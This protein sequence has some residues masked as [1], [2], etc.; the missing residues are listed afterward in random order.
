LLLVRTPLL[1]VLAA[2]HQQRQTQVQATTVLIPL[3]E[4]LLL[5]VV[6]REMVLIRLV[7]TVVRV[8]VV[9]GLQQQTRLEELEYLVRD[10]LVVQENPTRVEAVLIGLL[11]VAVARV[12]LV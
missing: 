1:S 8:V 9:P 6:V 3:L 4:Q 10:T 2:Q 12:Q 7:R 5:L 11:L